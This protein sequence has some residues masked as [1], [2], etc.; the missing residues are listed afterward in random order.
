MLLAVHRRVATLATQCLSIDVNGFRDEL[1]LACLRMRAARPTVSRRE[2]QNRIGRLREKC[3]GDRAEFADALDGVIEAL[4][5]D[6]HH[7]SHPKC[8]VP[9]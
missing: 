2:M 5:D 3:L 1:H 8:R 7:T 9:A 4:S 6:Y